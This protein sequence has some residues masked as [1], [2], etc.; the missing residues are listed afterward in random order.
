ITWTVFRKVV[1]SE[2]G[3]GARSPAYQYHQ[4]VRD[5]RR[6]AVASALSL[7]SVYQKIEGDSVISESEMKDIQA[8][9][10]LTDQPLGWHMRDENLHRFFDKKAAAVNDVRGHNWELLRQYSEAAGLYF[11]P[12][13]MPD[14]S[15]SHAI[16]WTDSADL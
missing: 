16:V 2:L 14:G 4:N 11:D 12:L 1:L 10:W 3:V 8:R 5:Y 9:L 7:L 6:T 15:A 13:E